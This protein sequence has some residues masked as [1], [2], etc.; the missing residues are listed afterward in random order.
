MRFDFVRHYSHRCIC[1]AACVAGCCLMLF[2]VASC[3]TVNCPLNNI[4][5]SH[6]TFYATERD[7]DGTFIG[8]SAVTVGDTLTVTALST[9]LAEGDTVIVNRA[10][11]QSGLQMPVSYYADVDTLLFTFTDNNGL[12][13]TDTVWVAKR[14][15]LHF[16]DP[17]C[18]VNMFHEVQSVRSTHQL[19]DTIV[20]VNADISYDGLENFQIYFYTDEDE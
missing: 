1:L 13:A 3:E 6:W 8:G 12:S 4:V 11:R 9:Y 19:I 5:E 14:N 15:Q 10:V 2:T 16:D 18:P 17:S 20:V 7:A